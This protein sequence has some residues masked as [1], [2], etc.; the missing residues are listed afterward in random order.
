LVR[1]GETFAG[2]LSIVRP[3][4]P[5]IL[6]TTDLGRR[7]GIEV[8]EIFSGL[9]LDSMRRLG[10]SDDDIPAVCVDW[11]APMLA[12]AISQR[13]ATKDRKLRKAVDPHDEHIL[14]IT[15]DETMIDA[16]IAR[17][18]LA[19]CRPLTDLISRALLI[20]SYHPDTDA[21]IYPDQCMVL[22]IPLAV[23]A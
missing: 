21:T 18:A 10:V 4:P 6:L 9:T 11:T 3:D 5:D 23:T 17:N 14:L 20:L 16:P 2:K 1:S 13:I 7:I 12:D 15:T 19:M 22:S 8:T